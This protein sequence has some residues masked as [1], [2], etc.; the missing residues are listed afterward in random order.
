M[1]HMSGALPTLKPCLL[2]LLMV[3]L[4]VRGLLADDE[5]GKQI[6]SHCKT[7]HGAHGLG[8][9]AGK[10]PRIAGMPKAYIERQLN[11]FKSRKRLN[12]PMIP[13][14]RDWRFDQEAI[15]VVADYVTA[16]PLRGLDIPAYEPAPEILDQFDSPA[17]LLEVGE[18]IFQDCVQCHGED[19]QGKPDKEG[20]PLVNQYPAYIRK[21]IGDFARGQRSHENS[22]P[23]FAELEADEVEALVAYLSKLGT[24]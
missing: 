18:D 6:Y 20:P 17:Q 21:Q 7:C 16:L 4:P 24:Q 8:G 5:T 15:A 12:K 11:N 3:L 13:L 9:E 1:C 23:L 19:G 2:I 10:Y 14:F 22:E